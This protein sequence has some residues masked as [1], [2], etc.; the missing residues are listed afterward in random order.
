MKLDLDTLKYIQHQF[1]LYSDTTVHSLGYSWLKRK[2]EELESKQSSIT[3]VVQAKPEK[4]RDC[5]CT[6]PVPDIMYGK[7]CDDCGKHLKHF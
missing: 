6:N 4:V 3:A 7:Y 5:N 2:I 1:S